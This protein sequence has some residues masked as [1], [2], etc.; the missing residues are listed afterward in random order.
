MRSDAERAYERALN[1]RSKVS[2]IYFICTCV[3]VTV[4]CGDWIKG[5]LAA[6][7]VGVLTSCW[8]TQRIEMLRQQIYLGEN[9]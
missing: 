3:V 9:K 2:I 7:V 6:S 5:F 8:Y 1:R 4:L